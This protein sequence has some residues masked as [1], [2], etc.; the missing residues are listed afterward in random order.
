MPTKR[1]RIMVNIPPE[2]E[3]LVMKRAGAERRSVANYIEKLISDAVAPKMMVE[4]QQ[5]PY[6]TQKKIVPGK[7]KRPKS[8]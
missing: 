3:E 4:E 1:K 8:A 2:L 5:A 7:A 6:Y